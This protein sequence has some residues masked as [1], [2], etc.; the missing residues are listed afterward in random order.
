MSGRALSCP[1]CSKSYGVSRSWRRHLVRDECERVPLDVRRSIFVTA[2]R[3]MREDELQ[4]EV[5]YLAERNG[6][7][8][9]HVR[10]SQ[11]RQGHHVTN[12]SVSGVPDLFMV[13]PPLLLVLELK[14][15]SGRASIEQLDWITDLQHCGPGV[16]AYVVRPADWPHLFD[17]LTSV[18]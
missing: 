3:D 14:S 7:R 11:V 2:A 8:F 16:E 6:W 9:F 1:Y 5:E 18:P 17:V 12:T 10:K 13:R 4:S 15:Q